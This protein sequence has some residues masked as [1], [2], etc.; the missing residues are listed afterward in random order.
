[1][2]QALESLTPFTSF[3][4]FSNSLPL[5]FLSAS[6]TT[7]TVSGR[8]NRWILL[9]IGGTA[10]TIFTLGGSAAI[11]SEYSVFDPNSNAVREGIPTNISRSRPR[12]RRNTG[13]FSP[14]RTTMFQ[15]ASY[16]AEKVSGLIPWRSAAS[17]LKAT[18]NIR[19]TAIELEERAAG[20]KAYREEV[21]RLN[22]LL[23]EAKAREEEGAK[24][25]DEV[26][27]LRDEVGQLKKELEGKRDEK[28]KQRANEGTGKT[29]DPCLEG[30][31][32][33]SEGEVISLLEDLNT[34]MLDVAHTITRAFADVRR[35]P[36]PL[37]SEEL[38]EDLKEAIAGTFEI[39]GPGVVELLQA[40]QKWGL[41]GEE[42]AV[43]VALKA[44]MAT[45]THW[46]ISSWYF[47]NPEDEH[48]LS[49]IYARVRETGERGSC[50]H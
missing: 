35:P 28:G 1:M 24:I 46:I 22:Q 6:Q 31:D 29:V 37:P 33:T 38:S 34:E 39:L 50:F 42:E 48:L 40:P 32:L 45:Y 26:E 10:V 7:S 14:C 49:E 25:R 47:E 23:E 30:Q 13:S 5:G 41:C 12:S 18:C 11:C 44:S 9:I 3:I 36:P 8:N 19:R 43:K 21:E 20:E 4:P 15:I 17:A 16:L 2:P 27:A